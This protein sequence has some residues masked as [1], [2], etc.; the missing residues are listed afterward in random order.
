MGLIDVNVVGRA[1][2]RTDGRTDGRIDILLNTTL[3]PKGFLPIFH[4]EFGFWD[5]AVNMTDIEDESRLPFRING[6]RGKIDDGRR[7]KVF[8]YK[9]QLRTE[10]RKQQRKKQNHYV[11]QSTCY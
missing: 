8:R 7:C 5:T 10:D 1:G 3:Q 11:Q 2:G 9:S 4:P 6:H